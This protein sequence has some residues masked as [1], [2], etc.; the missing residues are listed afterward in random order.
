M[1]MQ[2]SF[3]TYAFIILN[4]EWEKTE[5]KKGMLVGIRIGRHG[6]CANQNDNNYGFRW[7][8]VVATAQPMWNHPDLLNISIPANPMRAK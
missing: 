8:S 4:Y 3:P 1:L 5:L 7:Y 2:G 6:I